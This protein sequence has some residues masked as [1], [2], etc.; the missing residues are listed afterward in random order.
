MDF[1]EKI[2]TINW[3]KINYKKFNSPDWS[4]ENNFLVLHWWGWSSD[5]W[6]EVWKLLWEKNFNVFIPDLPWHWK[7]D[8]TRTFTLDDYW[9][10]V[11]KF[12]EEVWL[13][14]FSV[15]AHSNWWRIFLNLLNKKIF[16]QNEKISEN[17]WKSEIEIKEKKEYIEKFLEKNSHVA[18]K[19]QKK[20][21]IEKIFL[22]W[23]AWIRP[24]LNFQQK[25]IQAW[26]K[27]FPLF[28]Q[29][30]FLRVIVLKLIW[31]QD[32]LKASKNHHLR[33]TFL[34]VLNIDLLDIL[35]NIKEKIN[36]IWWDQDT[37]TPL[38]MWKKMNKLL[39]NSDLD[40]LKWQRHWI[41]LHAPKKLVT[42]I[43]SRF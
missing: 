40:I 20:F 1:E 29:V 35:P 22:M 6:A 39:I 7:T 38:W 14:N 36:L 27:Y 42:E 32:Y 33:Q 34:N 11:E 8:L 17:F 5:S 4:Q 31:W 3:K 2:L 25:V 30:S 24:K 10:F 43:I 41:H 16:H 13:K 12:C 19:L 28:K 9:V 37:Y 21:F 15:I 23:C 26:S 18:K